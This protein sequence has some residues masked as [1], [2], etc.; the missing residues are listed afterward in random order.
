MT[1]P[2][3]F[4]GRLN[5]LFELT[6][7]STAATVAEVCRRQVAHLSESHLYA[8]RSGDRTNPSL[9]VMRALGDYF[10]IDPAYFLTTNTAYAADLAA[11]AT[12]PGQPTG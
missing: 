9:L 1:I 6:G 3:D 8:L 11:A 4:T 10:G 12:R 2:N 7:A 5:R